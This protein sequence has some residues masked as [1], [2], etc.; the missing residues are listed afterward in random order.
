MLAHA[1]GSRVGMVDVRGASCWHSCSLSNLLEVNLIM[2]S[3]T[4]PKQKR[5]DTLTGLPPILLVTS[6]RN[7][8]SV[9]L[10]VLGDML[11]CVDG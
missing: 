10:Q 4:F 1:F 2:P 11:V 8:K 6:M 9:T 3:V 7:S 5:N